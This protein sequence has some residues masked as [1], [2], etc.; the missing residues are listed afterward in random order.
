MEMGAGSMQLMALIKTSLDPDVTY[1]TPHVQLYTT[2]S[3]PCSASVDILTAYF[4]LLT[5]PASHVLHL[6]SIHPFDPFHSFA[7]SHVC[8]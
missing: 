2:M 5:C 3:V 4:S 1:I 6:T 7:L 8:S